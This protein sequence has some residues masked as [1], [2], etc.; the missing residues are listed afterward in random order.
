MPHRQNMSLNA[1]LHLQSMFDGPQKGVG[2]RESRSLSLREVGLFRESSEQRN[3]LVGDGD[4][5]AGGSIEQKAHRAPTVPGSVCCGPGRVHADRRRPLGDGH[6]HHQRTSPVRRRRD[7][8]DLGHAARRTRHSAER[9]ERLGP[10]RPGA[11]TGRSGTGR[12][13]AARARTQGKGSTSA[14]CVRDQ[15]RFIPRR[16]RAHDAATPN[17]RQAT[18]GGAGQS[19]HAHHVQRRGYERR[20]GTSPRLSR[21][22]NRTITSDE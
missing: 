15:G 13:G 1:V 19:R 22:F 7:C 11:E 16:A 10:P 12:R 4:P 14:A 9:S 3:R 21:R 18:Q 20:N 5:Y 2:R 6:R 17:H 8:A